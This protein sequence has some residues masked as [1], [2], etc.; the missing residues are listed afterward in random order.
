MH[1]IH[2]EVTSSR[3][4]LI[5]GY[6]RDIIYSAAYKVGYTVVHVGK[7][8]GNRLYILARFADHPEKHLTKRWDFNFD[9]ED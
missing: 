6:L 5:P 9:E 2:R 4:S 3:R 1:Y 8:I 7:K